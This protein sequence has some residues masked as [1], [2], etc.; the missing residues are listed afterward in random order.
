MPKLMSIDL[1]PAEFKQAQI[2]NSKFYKIQSIGIAIIGIIAFLACLMVALRLLQSQKIVQLQSRASE[3]EQKVSSLK[4]SQGYLL[5]LKNRLDTINQYLGT[6]SKISAVY[7]LIERLLPPDVSISTISVSRD[8]EV[9]ILATS[10]NPN[11]LDLF[12]STLLSKD[13]SNGQIKQVNMDNLSRGKDG[14][15]RL[16]VTIKQK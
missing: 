5:L 3:A 10:S 12:L 14:I 6:P 11:S 9:S 15:Y 4:T 7:D 8:G 2:K 16:T 1:L 13:S